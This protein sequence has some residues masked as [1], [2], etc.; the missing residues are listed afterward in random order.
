MH[1]SQTFE[2]LEKLIYELK[3][4]NIQLENV[5][6]GGGDLGIKYT[7]DDLEPDLQEYAALV[8]RKLGNL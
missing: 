4:R 3:E 7:D 5:D 2:H 8:K 6:I 1:S